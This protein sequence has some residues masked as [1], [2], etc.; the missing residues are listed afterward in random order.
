MKMTGADYKIL[1]LENRLLKLD[2]DSVTAKFIIRYIALIK[3]INW[4]FR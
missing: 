3:K 2:K 4:R 1:E